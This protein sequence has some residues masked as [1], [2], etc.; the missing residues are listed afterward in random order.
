MTDAIKITSLDVTKTITETS[1][2][3]NTVLENLNGKKLEL[4]IDKGMI[5]PYFAST[6][7]NL[8]K[9]ENKSQCRLIKD[10]NSTKMK[11]F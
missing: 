2:K 8:F 10:F 6:L 7:V 4:L 3:N 11:D 5:A 1:N 9:P